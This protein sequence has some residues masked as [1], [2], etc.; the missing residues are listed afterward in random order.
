MTEI[1]PDDADRLI[2]NSSLGTTG[3][4][5]LRK[6]A[7]RNL[8]AAT[9]GRSRELP[10]P[11]TAGVSDPDNNSADAATALNS[12][13]SNK[14]RARAT[15]ES[16][17]STENRAA[18]DT[19]G[20]L[21]DAEEV[22]RLAAEGL[23]V[24]RFRDGTDD[25]RRR[26]RI[27]ATEIVVPLVF[28]RLTRPIERRRGHYRCAV[29]LQHLEPDCLD[30]FLD[31]VD[32]V[33]DALFAA[34]WPIENV[35]GWLSMRIPSATVD[36]YRRRRAERGA[37]MRPRVPSWLATELGN[38]PWLIE[39][40]TATLD[41]VGTDATAGSALWPLAAWAERRSALTS[42]HASEAAVAADV[43]TV[44]T[45]MRRR[46]LWYHNNVER[47]LGRKPVPV[48]SPANLMAG[49]R[50]EPQSVADTPEHA[51][52]TRDEALLLE[53]AAVAID[54][55]SYRLNQGED[56]AVAVP[57]VLRIVF[58]EV[59]SSYGLARPPATGET[60]PEQAAILVTDPARRSRIIATVIELTNTGIATMHGLPSGQEPNQIDMDISHLRMAVTLTP[61][62][63]PEHVSRLTSLAV[64][65]YARWQ[66]SGFSGDLD[67]AI[68]LLE[69]A[70]EL[71]GGPD[72][73]HWS[74]VNDFLSKVRHRHSH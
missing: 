47:P 60:G 21:T 12:R 9:V 6:R 17:I 74:F 48:W 14:T 10:Q 66:L 4:R 20:S 3:A 11:T 7:D 64:R 57:D 35:E 33:L 8:V 41:W 2:A 71:A 32:A 54:L 59:P 24:T 30:R 72:H 62:D 55:V 16:R 68:A 25:D 43:E 45:A 50:T 27:G 26:L 1:E 18:T 40:A 73:P 52:F 38:D 56:V 23:L 58:G 42:T 37:P 46:G 28:L 63:H 22:R 15:A 31:D 61:N 13:R 49:A 34:N 39:L 29:G 44:L 70:R 65:L 51:D 53:L 5:Q 36:G 69:E 67:E 19:K